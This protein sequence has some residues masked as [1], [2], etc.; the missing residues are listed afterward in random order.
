MYMYGVTTCSFDNELWSKSLKEAILNYGHAFSNS[1][2]VT[3]SHN[4]LDE[5]FS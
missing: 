5:N 4:S 2:P 3:H 1:Y